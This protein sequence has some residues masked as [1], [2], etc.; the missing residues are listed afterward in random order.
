MQKPLTTSH[1]AKHLGV[2]VSRLNQ[3]LGAGFLNGCVPDAKQG[4]RRKWDITSFIGTYMYFLFCS[5]G[6]SKKSASQVATQ[7]ALF[8]KSNPDE[9]V[10]AIVKRELSSEILA[11]KKDAVENPKSWDDAIQL[12]TFYNIDAARTSFKNHIYQMS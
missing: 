7:I 2:D 1:I 9:N 3:D 10:C 11:C 6:M 8:S 12:V 4:Q 5:Q